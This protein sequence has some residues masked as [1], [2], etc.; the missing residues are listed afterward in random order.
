[1]IDVLM[2]HGAGAAMDVYDKVRGAGSHLGP[3]RVLCTLFA[4]VRVA[5][6]LMVGQI[7]AVR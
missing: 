6:M 3:C 4:R 5:R 7:W 1:M 2:E